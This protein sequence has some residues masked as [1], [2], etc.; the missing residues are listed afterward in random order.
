MPNTGVDDLHEECLGLLHGRRCLTGKG[1]GAAKKDLLALTQGRS[2]LSVLSTG[3]F[4]SL[5][6]AV[7]PLGSSFLQ[8][9]RFEADTS[10][11]T[12]S[13]RAAQ[14][15][16][17]FHIPLRGDLEVAMENQTVT[18]APGEMI[19][20][21]SPGTVV[22][23]W[24]GSKDTLN[25][26]VDRRSVGKLVATQFGKDPGTPIAFPR[27]L[28]LAQAPA[29]LGLMASVVRD[30]AR[31]DALSR[32]SVMA[33]QLG[34]VLFSSFLAFLPNSRSDELATEGRYMPFYL[35]EAVKHIS[36]NLAVDLDMPVLAA[37]VGV[38]ERTLYSAFNKHLRTS[39]AKLLLAKRLEAARAYL[40]T[41]RPGSNRIGATA[42]A[43][44]FVSTSHFSREYHARFGESPRSTL[45]SN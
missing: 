23:S 18:A 12:V 38:S 9:T 11:Q 30:S 19:C 44:G 27:V 43:F 4:G 1:Y 26:V 7:V 13:S 5:T 40:L 10:C 17:I 34:D 8:F 39:P 31:P 36:R 45:H 6:S 2:V 3:R 29:V 22:K 32:S 16:Y 37:H 35:Q 33:R 20:V 25:Y 28:S 21:A 15:R 41:E 42:R 24:S 14:D